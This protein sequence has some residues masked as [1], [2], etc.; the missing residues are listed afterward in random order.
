MIARLTSVSDM[1]AIADVP[2]KTKN[3]RAITLLISPF[4]TNPGASLSA[5]DKLQ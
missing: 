5:N 1:A 2:N 3:V 4:P